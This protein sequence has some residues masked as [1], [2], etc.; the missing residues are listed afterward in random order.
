MA[1]PT[2]E[3]ILNAAEKQFAE[4]G[5]SATSL[6]EIAE[7]V[8]IRTPSIYKHFD[9]KKTLYKAVMK[10]LLD[11]YFELLETLLIAPADAKQAQKNLETVARHYYQ[12]PNLA[13]LVQHAAL[14]GGEE[15]ELLMKEWFSPFF[16][17]AA[18]LSLKTPAVRR[19]DPRNVVFLVMAFH[20]MLS[21]YV[22]MAPIHARLLGE[23]PLDEEA[24]ER[25]IAFLKRLAKVLWSAKQA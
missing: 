16:R 24:R 12:T 8:G 11:P 3:S 4:R 14:A 18:Q 2:A 17:R 21:G 5:Y 10:R 22:T 23:D 20:D 15:V 7:K 1:R 19:T 9:S 25:H 13:R 6:V